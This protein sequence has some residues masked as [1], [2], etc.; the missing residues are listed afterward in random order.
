MSDES[1]TA[2]DRELDE[3]EKI[4]GIHIGD[5]KEAETYSIFIRTKFSTIRRTWYAPEPFKLGVI[6]WMYLYSLGNYWWFQLVK[7]LGWFS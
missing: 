2:F 1:L 3:L 6:D 5:N 4:T 7:Y